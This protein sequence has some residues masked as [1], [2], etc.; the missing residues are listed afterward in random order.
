MGERKAGATAAGRAVIPALGRWGLS[1]LADVIYRTLVLLGPGDDAQLSRELGVEPARIGTGL[2]ELAAAG[3]VRRSGQ[4][5]QRMWVARDVT[6]V[7]TT[8]CPRRAPVLVTEQCRRHLAAVASVHLDRI[9]PSLIRV[10]PSRRCARNRIADLATMERREHLAI[11]TEDV[12]TAD[13]ARV[14]GPI[15]RSLIARGVRLRTLGLPP[16]D[17]RPDAVA[18]GVEHREAPVLPLKLMVFDRRAA[19]FPR[20]PA[21][22]DVGAVEVTDA[23]AVAHLTQLFYRIWRTAS[24]PSRQEVPTVVLTSREKTILTLLAAGASEEAAAGQLGLS[25]RTVVYT[26]RALMDRLG[27]DNRFQLALVLGAARAIPLPPATHHQPPEAT[28]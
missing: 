10:L 6:E 14:A 24:D 25:R 3:A 18:P 17:G 15:D 8:L 5:G 16:Q 28:R 7:T 13:A 11:N 21:D 20:D 22:F 1:P 23:D 9:P 2:E 12:I 19:L 4:G 26:I 27:V